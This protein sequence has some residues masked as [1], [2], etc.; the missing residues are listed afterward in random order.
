MKNE[1]FMV[2]N[3]AVTRLLVDFISREN[4]EDKKLAALE[5]LVDMLKPST[6]S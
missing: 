6:S 2:N 5:T 3:G 1:D 4:R